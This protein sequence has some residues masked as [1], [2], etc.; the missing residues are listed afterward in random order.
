MLENRCERYLQ[1]WYPGVGEAIALQR[2]PAPMR[3]FLSD[4]VEE[5]P[6]F[7]EGYVLPALQSED[8]YGMILGD[9]SVAGAAYDLEL[10]GLGTYEGNLDGLGHLGKSLWK[11]VTHALK[12]SLNP[13]QAIKGAI[14]F[15]KREVKKEVKLT[16]KIFRKYG[17]IILTVAG[18]VLSPFTGGAS[19]AA[20]A[21]LIAAQKAYQMK[22]AADKAKRESRK[23]AAAMQAQADAQNAQAEQQ[24]DAFYSQNQQWFVDQLG[25]TPDKW[26][27]LTLQQKIDLIN[28]GAS[29]QV[30]P[31]STPVSTPPSDV[32]PTPSTPSQ[33]PPQI[34][35]PPP[36]DTSGSGPPVT[37]PSIYGPGGPP[38]S[39]A[40]QAYQQQIQQAQAMPG[41]G[42]GTDWSQYVQP[43]AQ[44]A[45][46]LPQ[47][48]T[49]PV[50]Q[51]SMF[52]DMSGMMLPAALIAA[53]VIFTQGG[54]RGGSGRRTRRNPRKRRR[55]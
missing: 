40:Q 4:A 27:Q 31:N 44:A 18:A 22:A 42:A 14:G 45:G 23:E 32:M 55:W 24:V 30:P 3:R 37:T 20:A 2:L 41:G 12:K 39:G 1:D 52:G 9:M 19:M 26:A 11:R 10:C 33:P 48:Q 51:S 13:V 43:A 50:A 46:I 25:V 36:I 21:V 28:A 29:G 53:A 49:Q 6:E 16:E 7:L 15:T 17:A 47:Q 5:C 35:Q 54:S 8:P 34:Q 38:P